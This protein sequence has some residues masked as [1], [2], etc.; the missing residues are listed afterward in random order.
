MSPIQ[1]GN[2][3]EEMSVEQINDAEN[4]LDRIYERSYN[5]ESGGKVA[6]LG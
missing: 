4:E 6:N 1:N 5:D 2:P 3:F